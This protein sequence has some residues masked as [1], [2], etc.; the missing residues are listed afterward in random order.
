[1]RVDTLSSYFCTEN[2]NTVSERI[3]TPGFSSVLG[4]AGWF[5]ESG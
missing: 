2:V 4:N 5:G 3:V 1:M